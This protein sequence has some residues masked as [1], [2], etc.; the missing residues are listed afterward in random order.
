MRD[1]VTLRGYYNDF[2]TLLFTYIANKLTKNAIE[3]DANR[4]NIVPATRWMGVS[5]TVRNLRNIAGTTFSDK[6]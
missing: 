4:G 3:P 1:D 2:Q 6:N 5:R